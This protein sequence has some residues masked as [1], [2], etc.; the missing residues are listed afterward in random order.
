MCY[1]K[2]KRVL[3]TV[4]NCW[5]LFSVQLNVLILKIFGKILRVCKEKEG[6][7][8]SINT[9]VVILLRLLLGCRS[10]AISPDLPQ[11]LLLIF[12]EETHQ[13]RRCKILIARSAIVPVHVL[14]ETEEHRVNDHLVDGKQTVRHPKGEQWHENDGHGPV[15]QRGVRLNRGNEVSLVFSSKF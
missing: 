9:G 11:W 14:T 2:L 6:E 1:D 5:W 3:Q 4:F 8:T 13:R 15:V 12:R 10:I 7:R